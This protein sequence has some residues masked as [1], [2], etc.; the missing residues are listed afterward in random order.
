MSRNARCGPGAI[1]LAIAT[2]RR[3]LRRRFFIYLLAA[4][5]D[6]ERGF[7]YDL[8]RPARDHA[9]DLAIYCYIVHILRDLAK[10]AERSPRLIT[11]PA[12]MLDAVGLAR[13]ELGQALRDKS[14][15]IGALAG[16]LI[17]KALPHRDAGHK[18]LGAVGRASRNSR[19]RRLERLN[20]GL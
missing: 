7:R 8:D 1:F 14:P 5:A 15:A 19:A 16:L 3:C 9:V 11:I 12:D 20:R 17:E 10:D 6:P 18:S 2:A 13:D 4:D